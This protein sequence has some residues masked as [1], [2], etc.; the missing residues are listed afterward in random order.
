MIPAQYYHPI[1]LI[2]ISFLSIYNFRKLSKTKA[3]SIY[4]SQYEDQTPSIVLTIFMIFFI[5]LRPIS[6]KYFV[7]MAGTARIWNWWSQGNVYQYQWQYKNKI[8]D[9]LRSY[10]STYGMPVE[11]FF[12]II[13]LIYFL[14]IYIACRKFFPKNTFF[15]LLVY[16]IAFSTFSYATNGIKAGSAASIFLVALA[17]H[18]NLKI[19]I[20]L[21]LI[22]WG[23]HHSMIMVLSCLIVVYFYRKA[24]FY[25]YFW[26]FA[27]IIA[28]LHITIFQYFF[29]RY[30]YDSGAAYLLKQMHG[31][32]FRLDFI[33][34]SAVPVIIGYYIIF[35]KKIQSRKYNFL[36]NMYL[37]TNSIWMLCMYAEFTNRI[38]YLSWFIHPW[39]MIY[40]F[41]N[42]KISE[43][44]FKYV[45]ILAMGHL[46]FNLFL[47]LV[48]W[49]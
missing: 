49:S 46:A 48:Y 8:Y 15:A 40:P 20:P 29:A 35:I 19:L 12:F 6:G 37:M 42:E 16:L 31:K 25:F 9:N 21:S 41:L 32:G 45:N 27:F 33:A 2:L 4:I 5:G 30:D 1:F 3:E 26:I 11:Y 18:E 34:Y 44:Q 14:C 39:V 43:L 38:A 10:M 36:L 24:K 22:S 7:D 17:Y 47:S 13:A 28:A 23:F